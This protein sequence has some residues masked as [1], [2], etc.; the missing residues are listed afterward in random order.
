MRD[1]RFRRVTLVGFG[2]G[3]W[4]L[5]EDSSYLVSEPI[6]WKALADAIAKGSSIE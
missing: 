6:S 4:I 5:G 2:E 1:R 3:G